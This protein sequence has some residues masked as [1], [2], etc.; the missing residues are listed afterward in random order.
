MQYRQYMLELY[1][2]IKE[3]EEKK[4]LLGLPGIRNNND[5]IRELQTT[6]ITSLPSPVVSPQII[7]LSTEIEVILPNKKTFKSTLKIAPIAPLSSI[8]PF[9]E[10]VCSEMNARIKGNM[11]S[12]LIINGEARSM[13]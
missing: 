11:P 5:I 2:S 13:E 12:T 7:N 8:L 1:S 3:V 10:T 4:L 9:L 6:I